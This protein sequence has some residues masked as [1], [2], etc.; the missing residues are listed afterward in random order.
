MYYAFTGNLLRKKGLKLEQILPPATSFNVFNIS[1]C[2]RNFRLELPLSDLC[3]YIFYV[4]FQ[5]VL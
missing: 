4:Y 2:S 1:D 5:A 3:N